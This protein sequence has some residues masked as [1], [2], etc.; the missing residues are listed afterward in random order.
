MNTLLIIFPILRNHFLHFSFLTHICPV[1]GGKGH[2]HMAL[3]PPALHLYE[4]AKWAMG[5]FLED[6]PVLG[7]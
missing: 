4:P 7:W 1:S 3:A 5:V 2:I 6:I